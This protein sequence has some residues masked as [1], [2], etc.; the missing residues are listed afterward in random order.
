[1]EASTIF[2]LVQTVLQHPKFV[3]PGSRSE[4]EN[5]V[6]VVKHLSMMITNHPFQFLGML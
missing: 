3:F 4:P 5:E 2:V 1:M 6:P